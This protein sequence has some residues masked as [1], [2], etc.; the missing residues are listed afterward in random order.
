MICTT[1]DKPVEALG[2]GLLDDETAVISLGTYIALMVNGKAL[3]KDPVAYWPIMSSIPETLLY[4]GYGIRKGMW[5]VSW[6]R[7]MLGES[8]IQDARA[9]GLSP[10]DLL[11]KKAAT[12][13]PGCNGLMT[14]LDWLTNPW[15]PYKRGIMIGFDSSMDYAWIYRSIL[16]SVALTL[17]NNYDN[18]CNE[19]NHFAKHIIITGGG[20]NSDLF[21]QIF[22]DVFNLPARRNAING[23]ASLGAAINAAVGLGL[24]PSYA[25]AVANMVRV[26]DTFMPI[27]KN[28]S[29]YEALNKGIFR[30]L[31]TY[32][33]TILKKSYAVTH[34][35]L[36]NVDAIKSWSNA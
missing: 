17:K 11:N 8:L 30:E 13:P 23:C 14:V 2:A 36:E 29:R 18:M 3:P 6:L 24:Y 25:T 10:E 34:G 32:T 27:E 4:E 12:V 21:M 9:Q 31:T 1:S 33:D 20:S 5:T 15:E 28:A 35:S 16:E 26:K 22:A 7:D 19:M